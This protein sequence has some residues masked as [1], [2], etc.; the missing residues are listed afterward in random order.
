MYI[1]VVL[2]LFALPSPF[3]IFE[4]LF[5]HLYKRILIAFQDVQMFLANW[6]TSMVKK[7][8]F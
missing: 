1:T 7:P 4:M 5:F 3:T 6:A 8:Q 2:E